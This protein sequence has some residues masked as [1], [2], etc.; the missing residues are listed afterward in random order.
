VTR[1]IDS[2]GGGRPL[3][4]VPP[5]PDPRTDQLLRLIRIVERL[6]APDGCPWDREQT[7]RSLAP[8]L[9]EEAHELVEAIEQGNP[10]AECEEAG[11]V[12]LV[13]ALLAQVAAEDGRFDLEAAARAVGDKL[14]RRHP[15]VFGEVAVDGT[16]NVIAN[17]EA[18]KR[19]ERAARKGEDTSALAGVPAALGAVQRAQRLGAKA[20]A[21]D[22]R[23][24]DARGA[25]AKVR[26]EVAE[27]EQAFEA[28]GAAETGAP[29]PVGPAREHLVAELGDVL[30]AC[31]QLANY[32]ECDAEAAAREATRRFE[33]RFRAMEAELG[34]EL[35]GRTLD[36][37]MAAWGR[38]KRTVEERSTDRE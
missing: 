7:L 3:E 19:A 2:V 13:V 35:R 18:I 5:T 4:P 36:D 16:E 11:D 25:L 33:A 27:L 8:T 6:R 1:P 14:I 31:A 9:I 24:A 32:L 30:L 12:L 17:W 20:M 15:H 26:E 37:L 38:A 22:F 23:W 28:A 34:G 21:V 10:R 29:P